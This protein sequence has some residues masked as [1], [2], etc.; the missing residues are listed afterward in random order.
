[1]QIDNSICTVDKILKI[2]IYFLF[3]GLLI[4]FICCKNNLINSVIYPNAFKT[5]HFIFESAFDYKMTKILLII[6]KINNSRRMFNKL[7]SV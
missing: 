4:V 6:M 5:F 2:L 1:M 3:A 7:S